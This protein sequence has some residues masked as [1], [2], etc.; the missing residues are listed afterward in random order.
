MNVIGQY[1][2]Q[3]IAQSNSSITFNEIVINKKIMYIKCLYAWLIKCNNRVLKL[4][5]F[6]YGEEKLCD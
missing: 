3:K 4:Y 5:N 6:N 2:D 1:L